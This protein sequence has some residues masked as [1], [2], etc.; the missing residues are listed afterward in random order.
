MAAPR[1]DEIYFEH[2]AI[3]RQVKVSAID[4]ASGTEVSIVGPASASPRDLEALA[5]RKLLA[6][7]GRGG[8]GDAGTGGGGQA[9]GSGGRGIL[10]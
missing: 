6:K 4:G 8:E 9:G 3:G 2:H 10:A 1:A 5:L 7:L